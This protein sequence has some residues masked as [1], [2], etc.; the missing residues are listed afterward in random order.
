MNI[1]VSVAYKDL[2]KRHHVPVVL[3]SLER[4]SCR[5]DPADP[6]HQVLL[7]LPENPT[8]KQKRSFDPIFYSLRSINRL[9][10]T[11]QRL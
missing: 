3:A 6:G 10:R 5:Q 11:S 7:F 9:R 1:R 4:Q 2:G 8:T